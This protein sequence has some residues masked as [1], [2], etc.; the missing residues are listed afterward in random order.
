MSFCLQRA[1]RAACSLQRFGMARLYCSLALTC[2]MK[3]STK[4]FFRMLGPGILFASTCIG[5]SHLVQ[6]T[7]AGASYGFALV[8]FVL[9]ANL[10]KYPFF[11]FGSRYAAATGKSIL[12]GYLRMG[13]WSLILYAVLSLVSM[14]TV[15]AAVTFVTAG[16]L[17][18]LT[19][20]T[21]DTAQLSAILLGLCML[22]LAVGKYNLLENLLK[23]IGAVLLISTLVAFFAAIFNGPAPRVEGFTAPDLTAP[24]SFAFIIALM[25]WMPTAVDLSAWNSI[26]AVE[27]YRSSGLKPDLK[28]TLA[29]FN[30]GYIV[31]AVLAICFL[32]LGSLVLYGTGTELANSSGGFASQIISLFTESIGP[33]CYWVIALAAFSTMFSTTITVL[34]GYSRAMNQT[35]SL[36]RKGTEENSSRMSYLG[37]MAVT[38]VVSW[39]VISQFLNNL[40]SL[41]DL[42]TILSFVIA[43]LI[44]WLNYRVIHRDEVGEAF[45]PKPW[46]RGLAL[47][48]LIF[49]TLF[50]VIYIGYRLF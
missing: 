4:S 7:R 34:D 39:L 45:R 5:V 23:V 46:L 15:T 40:T 37:I 29:D 30:F 13:R 35:L 19:G 32:T 1:C 36:L 31:T 50:T 47:A 21:L 48:G 12:S 44:A 25:G 6:S 33:W 18:T 14:F 43:P 8:I 38:A 42:A 49:L 24:A 3:D 9:L 16:L 20:S 11:E 17:S 22:V 26:W 41:V 28:S 27:K 2:L 10:F